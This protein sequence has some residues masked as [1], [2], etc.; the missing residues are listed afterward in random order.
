MYII[1]IGLS[2][3]LCWLGTMQDPLY[4]EH[5]LSTS[6]LLQH[7]LRSQQQPHKEKNISISQL[8]KLMLKE[9]LS[10]NLFPFSAVFSSVPVPP[11]SH[12]SAITHSLTPKPTGHLWGCVHSRYSVSSSEINEGINSTFLAGVWLSR[13]Q[14]KV[15]G[16]HFKGVGPCPAI[17]S[18][19]GYF[20]GPR[21]TAKWARDVCMGGWQGGNRSRT[22]QQVSEPRKWWFDGVLT[23]TWSPG[24]QK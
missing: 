6:C 22:N 18:K 1:Q 15:A 5:R 4:T 11:T 17:G 14:M 24:I 7:Y 21:P 8:R 10:L 3:V 19:R 9:D 20:P 16:T 2:T 13:P 12:C 23:A